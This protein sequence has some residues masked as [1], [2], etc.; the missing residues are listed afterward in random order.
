MTSFPFLTKSR[1][2]ISLSI[3]EISKISHSGQLLQAG[4][5]AESCQAMLRKRMKFNSFLKVMLA[6]VRYRTRD[7]DKIY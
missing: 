2:G 6:E 7:V 5:D 4:E 3:Y 1:L